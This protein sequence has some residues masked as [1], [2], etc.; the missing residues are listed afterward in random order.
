[1]HSDCQRHFMH[2]PRVQARAISAQHRSNGVV[3][4]VAYALMSAIIALWMAYLSSV[5]GS[6]LSGLNLVPD[7]HQTFS[8]IVNRENKGDR[9]AGATFD[10][11][12]SAVRKIDPPWP[13]VTIPDSCQPGE[14]CGGEAFL[15]TRLAAAR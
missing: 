7:N 11:R 4:T 10:D 13:A 1:M 2:R 3:V 9:L 5:T 12:W 14:R 8:S 6:I 15:L